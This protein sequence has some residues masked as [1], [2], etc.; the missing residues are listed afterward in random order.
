MGQLWSKRSNSFAILYIYLQ[1]C[2]HADVGNLAF[3]HCSRVSV[4]VEPQPGTEFW[5]E[6]RDRRNKMAKVICRV[7][8]G[9]FAVSCVKCRREEKVK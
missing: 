4:Q 3:I 6:A 8:I 9:I 2:I 5:K 7:I 1:Y